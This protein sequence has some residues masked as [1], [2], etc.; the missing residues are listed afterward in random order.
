MAETPIQ[1]PPSSGSTADAT[2][3]AIAAL[4]RI[5]RTSDQ[6][7]ALRAHSLH[8]TFAD[9]D[10][11]SDARD[12][13]L[14]TAS[15]Q[16]S[17]AV[18]A[19]ARGALRQSNYREGLAKVS[20]AI[21]EAISA[22]P[23]ER[24]TLAQHSTLARESAS[25][26]SRLHATESDTAHA[27]IVDGHRKA[28]VAG[29]AGD[30]HDRQDSTRAIGRQDV[31]AVTGMSSTW[32]RRDTLA[33][34]AES[35]AL[36]STYRDEVRSVR[37]D[38]WAEAEIARQEVRDHSVSLLMTERHSA[39]A[40]SGDPDMA[41]AV[42]TAD[43]EALRG[44]KTHALR[45]AELREMANLL[46][47]NAAYRDQ[48]LL[49]D[50][51]LVELATDVSLVQHLQAQAKEHV[52]LL[53]LP[54]EGN[55]ADL[56]DAIEADLQVLSRVNDPAERRNALR[57]LAY[58]DAVYA[59]YLLKDHPDLQAEMDGVTDDDILR[60]MVQGHAIAVKPGVDAE[61]QV[62]AKAR[63]DR[64]ALERITTAAAKVEAETLIAEAIEE[65]PGYQDAVMRLDEAAR[66]DGMRARLP[67]D[68]DLAAL[69]P[70]VAGAIA[71][72]DLQDLRAVSS[73]EQLSAIAPEIARRRDHPAYDRALL[74]SDFKT[75]KA[76]ESLA[77][78]AMAKAEQER[79]AAPRRPLQGVLL[80]QGRAPY[81][82]DV[83]QPDTF[84]A[85]Y[86]DDSGREG[87]VW[88]RHLEAALANA[89]VAPGQRFA[90][91]RLP[92][93]STSTGDASSA[94]LSCDLTE[95]DVAA[96]GDGS[97]AAN[98]VPSV[99]P[100]AMPSATAGG[101]TQPPLVET[102]NAASS[103]AVLVAGPA[104]GAAT[105]AQPVV[106]VEAAPQ[107]TPP[108]SRSFGRPAAN[109]SRDDVDDAVPP[110]G[111][112]A[113]A[114]GGPVPTPVPAAQPAA[115]STAA[116]PAPAAAKG[117]DPLIVQKNGFTSG[118]APT[119]RPSPQDF[120]KL[121]EHVTYETQRDGSVLYLLRMKPAFV[122]HGQQILMHKEGDGDEQAILAA[123]L[124]AK[125]KWGGKLELTGT[126]EFKARALAAIV[127][128]NVEVQFKNPEQ[129]ARWRDLK[130]KHDDA[131]AALPAQPVGPQPMM[132]TPTS[133]LNAIK[134]GD[135]PVANG[136]PASAPVL[137]PAPVAQLGTLAASLVPIR[138]L[139]WWH[140]ERDIAQKLAQD[141]KGV[142]Q[143]L[144][145]LG[146][147]PGAD[148]VFWFD[149]AGRRA[150]PPT[151]ADVFVKALPTPPDG[152]QPRPA[153]VLVLRSVTKTGEGRYETTALLFKPASGDHLQGFVVV[154]GEKRHVLAQMT[155]RPPDP[156]TGEIRSSFLRLLER[157]GDGKKEHWREIGY[158]NAI[159]HRADK[160]QVHFDEVMLTVGSDLVKA[161]VAG[162][163]DEGLH[164]SLGFTQR[165]TS[166]S[167]SEQPVD[168]PVS[169][170]PNVGPAAGD[171]EAA[172]GMSPSLPTP[173]PSTTRPT[174]RPRAAA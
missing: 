51:M 147:E 169:T 87:T 98:A 91:A 37:P 142:Q 145:Q 71:L 127:K 5:E 120:A 8:S 48:A 36:S 63:A 168:Q 20:P 132:G 78:E 116:K 112:A 104:T 59:R 161:R 22:Y 9:A 81:Q 156:T 31:Q 162:D 166:R 86:V 85:R 29:A 128:N 152:T 3:L 40:R 64:D 123:I 12:F 62:R 65:E 55:A 41:R 18:A 99:V 135:L 148:Q 4:Q 119:Q 117:L 159:N 14:L 74:A 73:H 155:Q 44:M 158:G 56:K 7:Q 139:D 35:G 11:A 61:R 92:M 96:E 60:E 77:W 97:Y 129:D 33:A 114:P 84:Y 160:K 80:E 54:P 52:H 125:Q 108:R 25:I 23:A 24:L 153:P 32:V 49:S 93:S 76:M 30:Q 10:A 45:N 140:A 110:A 75:A 154:N 103:G 126:E 170:R 122:D 28:F 19:M 83:A 58:N 118:D 111:P 15:D 143:H 82:G 6:N 47:D 26:A 167:T 149:K 57:A 66:L 94:T 106:A 165:Q 46:R 50:A 69:E 17:A 109:Q 173:A 16:Q 70:E 27:A 124:L 107:P 39:L 137:Q 102:P 53:A 138:A 136:A 144:K 72:A 134:P 1:Q 90:L 79:L 171:R 172:V 121:L 113:A 163:V 151:D 67:A 115:A 130:K 141:K 13:A 2:A 43:V 34:I 38:L 146:P 133:A 68:K 157:T 88:G 131:V 150:D 21:T 164:K 95:F 89:G 101:T 100:S 42:A 105:P 174:P